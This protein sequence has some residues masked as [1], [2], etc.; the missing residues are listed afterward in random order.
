MQQANGITHAR[1]A[2]HARYILVADAVESGYLA[3]E[4]DA[5]LRLIVFYV[6]IDIDHASGFLEDVANLPGDID[7][8]VLRGA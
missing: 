1:Q 8:T 7:L 5:V 6:P 4:T 2:K 3:V